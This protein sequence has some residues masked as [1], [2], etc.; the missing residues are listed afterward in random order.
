MSNIFGYD[1]YGSNSS[2]SSNGLF[3]VNLVDYAS[4]RNGS[5]RKLVAAHYANEKAEEEGST[6]SSNGVKDSKQ[7]LTSIGDAAS[8]LKDAASK[9]R[10][11]FK[12]TNTGKGYSQVDY[13]TDEMYSAVKDF[14]K[15]YNSLIDSA[16]KSETSSISKTAKNMTTY[17]AANKKALEAVGITVGSDSK[18]SIDEDKFK[19]ASKSRVQSL[20]QSTGGF[21]YQ[22]SSKAS[23]ISITTTDLAKKV[24]SSKTGKSGQSSAL[25]SFGTSSDSTKT[26]GTIE[27]AAESASKSLAKLLETGYK[28]KF[29]KVNKT[30]ENG[31][32]YMDYDKDAIYS[33]VKDFIKN[34][35]TLLD[36]TEDSKT[37]SITQA[38]KTMI[39]YVAANKSKLSDMG[40]TIDSNNKIS[41]N[42]EA[43]KKADMATV[44]SLFQDK[45]S[46]GKQLEQQISKIDM[47]AE[48]EA[49][50]SNTYNN[51]GNYTYNYNSG[52][53]FNTSF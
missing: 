15:S 45:G 40:I 9:V 51:D 2:S 29:N 8:E 53:W 5:Y 52:D 25:K 39:N 22:I 48:N 23:R 33:A 17:T 14:I 21:A 7:T 34:Y 30:D 46:L 11:L 27:D 31:K 12:T 26:L 47:Y 19:E 50:K 13:D 6:S 35:N 4:I 3:G 32:I 20:F 18:L 44:K 41:I 49:S 10:S 42:E 16:E 37:Q 43:F 1:S 28:S 36:K 38:R 24:D